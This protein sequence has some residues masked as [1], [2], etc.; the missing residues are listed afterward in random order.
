MVGK[1]VT[2][3][4]TEGLSIAERVML[5]HRIDIA[6]DGKAATVN[7]ADWPG[8]PAPAAKGIITHYASVS[9]VHTLRKE[10]GGTLQFKTTELLVLPDQGQAWRCSPA[11]PYCDLAAH[12]ADACMFRIVTCRLGCGAIMQVR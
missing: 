4:S 10:R 12:M 8:M 7:E 3:Y 6:L 9:G 1:L 11:I 5:A 2:L